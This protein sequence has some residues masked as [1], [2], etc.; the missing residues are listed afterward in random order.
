MSDGQRPRVMNSGM[1]RRK[2]NIQFYVRYIWNSPLSVRLSVS[3]IFFRCQS[4]Q[5]SVSKA[6]SAFHVLSIL[7]AYIACPDCRSVC[8]SVWLS[9]VVCLPISLSVMISVISI[10]FLFHD[11]I[12]LAT[13]VGLCVGHH[14]CLPLSINLF[15]CQ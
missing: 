4:T 2:G 10:F 11:L 12:L 8:R 7:R 3:M 13:I 15:V 1:L 14:D 9:S 6:L 5:L